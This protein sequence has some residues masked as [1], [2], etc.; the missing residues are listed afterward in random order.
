MTSDNFF[1]IID[2]NSKEASTSFSFF[3]GNELKAY[4]DKLFEVCL[5]AK[6]FL[7]FACDERSSDIRIKEL[8]HEYYIS[9]DGNIINIISK[10]TSPEETNIKKKPHDD[11][12]QIDGLKAQKLV[13]H[14]NSLCEFY[15]N[16]PEYSIQIQKK[17]RR[18]AAPIYLIGSND[19]AIFLLSQQLCRKYKVTSDKYRKTL[20]NYWDMDGIHFRSLEEYFV[21]CNVRKD[22]LTEKSAH[23]I[24]ESIHSL[25]K[26]NQN[27]K[28]IQIS[29]LQHFLFFIESENFFTKLIETDFSIEYNDY[30]KLINKEFTSNSL[31]VSNI[32]SEDF[33]LISLIVNVKLQ[34]E[35]FNYKANRKLFQKQSFLQSG[36]LYFDTEELCGIFNKVKEYIDGYRKGISIRYK[37]ICDSPLS[38][39]EQEKVKVFSSLRFTEKDKVIFVQRPLVEGAY[40]GYIDA[41]ALF[42]DP[43]FI[44]STNSLSFSQYKD[45][46]SALSEN[47]IFAQLLELNCISDN[48]FDKIQLTRSMLF[49]DFP[50][51]LVNN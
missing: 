13:H 38:D 15:C 7:L 23:E 32:L 22:S 26:G 42:L 50:E 51:A 21:K 35:I 20:A 11:S 33:P 10:L 5:I 12:F 47:D 25:L 27:L 43:Q 28:F 34:Y 30:K 31:F 19:A 40:D 18:G 16:H 46:I 17:D 2:D 37:C 9:P 14:I 29:L 1:H 39:E 36:N 3:H 6:A 49:P 8:V 48:K 24:A 44:K 41:E 45:L 4:K